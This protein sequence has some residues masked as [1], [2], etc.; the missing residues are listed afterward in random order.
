MSKKVLGKGISALIPD[1]DFQ[2][3]EERYDRVEKGIQNID[4]MFLRTNPDQPRKSFNP[5]SL[6]ELA[7]SIKSK[8][9]IQPVIAEKRSDEEYI[10]IAGERRFRAAQIAE[11][12]NIPVIVRKFSAEEKLEIALIENIQREDLNPIEEAEAY[13]NLITKIGLNQD[14]LAKRVGKNRSTVANSIRLLKLPKDI[15]LAIIDGELSPGHARALLSLVNPADQSVLFKEIV[16]KGLSVR[17]AEK[18]A[19]E[20][21]AGQRLKGKKDRQKSVEKP[22]EIREIEDRFIDSLG[23]KV[24]LKGSI[25]KGKIV[26]DYFSQEDLERIFNIISET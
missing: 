20:F 22:I 14:D 19:G 13:Q 11:C 10:I 4:L 21:N 1:D 15:Q 7:E 6:K 2:K 23:T 9:I 24:T 18:K 25:K 8:G 17:L 5:E 12:K 16:E 26:I 3:P